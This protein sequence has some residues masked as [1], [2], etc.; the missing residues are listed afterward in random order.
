[1]Q[2]KNQKVQQ[3][4]G[5]DL[6]GASWGMDFHEE[7][8]HAFQKKMDEENESD[9]SHEGESDEDEAEKLLDID[10]LRQREGLTER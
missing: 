2:F 1:M 7:E 6:G 5:E 4:H 9:E 10:V 3:I 8:I